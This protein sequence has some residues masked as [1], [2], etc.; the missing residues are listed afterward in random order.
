M[1]AEHACARACVCVRAQPIVGSREQLRVPVHVGEPVCLRM[2]V[3]ACA[4]V[5]ACVR[6]RVCVRARTCVCV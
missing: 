5:R 6:V 1:H 3:C 4:C 2:R